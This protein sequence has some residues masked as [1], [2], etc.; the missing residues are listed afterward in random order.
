MKDS[1]SMKDS[2]SSKKPHRAVISQYL[3]RRAAAVSSKSDVVI[4]AV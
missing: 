4:R 2:D 3:R 1:E